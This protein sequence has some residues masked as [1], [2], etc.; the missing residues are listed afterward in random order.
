LN[1]VENLRYK[2]ILVA[3]LDWGLGHATRCIPIIRLLQKNGCE[4]TIAAS[5]AIKILLQSEFPGILFID[6][7][8][9]NIQ[10]SSNK[11]LLPVKIL[12]QLPKIVAAVRRENAWLK[13]LVDEKRFDAVI[14]DNRFGLFTSKIPCVFITHQLLIQAPFG[15]LQN[16]VQKLNYRYINRYSECWVPDFEEGGG[17]AGKLSHPEKLPAVPVR[18]LGP[19]SRFE[20]I[21]STT[22]PRY[23]WLMII[24][25]PEPQRSMLEKKL[26]A[27]APKLHGK[28][29]LV[30][31][32]PGSAEHV[33]VPAN[34]TAVNHLTTAQM[35]DAIVASGYIVSRCGYTT[36]M[37]MLAMGK[38]AV[39]IPTP[40]QTEQ[41][42][43]APHLAKQ[44]WCYY[45]EQ[46]DD[47]EQHLNA[48]KTFAYK[49]PDVKQS[50]LESVVKSWLESW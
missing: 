11:R 32:K 45:C 17:L 36:V 29:L 39:F 27:V 38:K 46:D 16:R 10:Y 22:Q 35:Q 40:G 37:E 25:G 8:G 24:S 42:Y 21:A 2:K 5:G 43:L 48:A 31:G 23:S 33:E 9:Y 18:Y 26:L 44:G 12:L 41:E 47:V 15:W 19:L 4:V 34:C 1:F 3:P 14:S 13:K 30:R 50:A 28:V 6:L 20:A 7:N 49:L